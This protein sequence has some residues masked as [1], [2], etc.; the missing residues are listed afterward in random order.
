[1][2]GIAEKIIVFNAIS[3]TKFEFSWAIKVYVTLN[4]LF[5]CTAYYY[6][7]WKMHMQFASLVNFVM[8]VQQHILTSFWQGAGGGGGLRNPFHSVGKCF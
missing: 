6:V 7:S 8:C 2:Q 3:G 4:I 1:M 5:L